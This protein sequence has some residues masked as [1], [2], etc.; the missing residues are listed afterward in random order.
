MG[1]L[2]FFSAEAMPPEVTDLSGLL[3]GP[4]QMVTAGSGARI[5]V[6]VDEMWRARAVARQIEEAGLP[7]EIARSEEGR[8]LVRT[9]VVPELSTL[10][11]SWTRGAVKSVPTTWVPGARELR[12]WALAAG[13][14]E[15]DGERFVLGLDAHAPESHPQLAL[16]LMRAGIAPTLIGTRGA[17]PGLRIAGR[18]RLMR[19]A[20]NIGEPPEDADPGLGWPRF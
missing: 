4:G 18:R 6:V 7:V 15:N 2:S 9:D 8:R 19:L 3:A 13:Y 20:E 12:M 17:R 16:A 1:Q 14:G 10:A 11:R 5:S